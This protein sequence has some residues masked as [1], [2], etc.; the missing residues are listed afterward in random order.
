M[1]TVDRALKR[2]VARERRLDKE[3]GDDTD[4]ALARHDDDRMHC[5]DVRMAEDVERLNDLELY[6]LGFLPAD[7]P[8]YRAVEDAYASGW[9]WPVSPEPVF[10]IGD[11]V[12]DWR[13]RASW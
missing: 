5:E 13:E 12:L 1:A 2:L 10:P 8:A 4:A 11:G 3:L 6:R 9:R 7:H